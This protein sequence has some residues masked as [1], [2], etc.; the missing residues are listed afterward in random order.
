MCSGVRYISLPRRWRGDLPH[1]G[2]VLSRRRMLSPQGLRGDARAF[3]QGFQLRPH[4]GGMDAARERA[5]REAAIGAADHVVAPDDPGKPY[6]AL[7]DEFWMLDDIGGVT[8]HPR[9][10][11]LARSELD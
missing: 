2:E 11:D 4:D 9:D 7:G 3:G 1:K 5:L 8:D 6:D 10:Q